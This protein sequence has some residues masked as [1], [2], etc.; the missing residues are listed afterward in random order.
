MMNLG[1]RD[2]NLGIQLLNVGIREC[3][4]AY[5]ELKPSL[6]Y[7]NVVDFMC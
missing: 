1:I 4:G 6:N 2:L 5:M 7:F 3:L